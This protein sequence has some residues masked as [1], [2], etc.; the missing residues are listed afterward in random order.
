MDR[1]EAL[2]LLATGAALPLA[3]PPLLAAMRQ[4]RVLLDATPSMRTLNAHQQAMVRTIAELIIPKTDTPG[5]TDVGTTEFIDLI[6]TEWFDD[7]ERTMF[8]SGLADVDA[9]SQALFGK[10]FVDSPPAQQ[11]DILSVLGEE[12][13]EET[14][15][16]HEHARPSRR[17]PA[18]SRHFYSSMRWLTLTAYYTSEAGATEELHYEIIP[19]RHAGCA[20]VDS[21]KGPEHP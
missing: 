10:D 1:R 15:R 11:A 21:V 12:M 14:A 3:N 13:A 16:V 20:S 17:P 18:A 9:R 5:A 19:A 8:L 7:P 4:A 6:L 2:R